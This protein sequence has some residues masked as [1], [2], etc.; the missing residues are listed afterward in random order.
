MAD[1]YQNRPFPSADRGRGADQQRPGSESDPLAELARLIGQADPFASS[2]QAAAAPPEPPEPA[3]AAPDRRN[4]PMDYASSSQDSASGQLNWMRRANVQAQPIQP[5]QDFSNVVSPPPRHQFVEPELDAF[6]AEEQPDFSRYDDVLY[7]QIK[8]GE[9]D[10]HRDPA[11]PDDPYA[12]END[13]FQHSF[14]EDQPENRRR[15]MAK[16]A[17]IIALLA[18]VGTGGAYAF[19]TFVGPRHRG[20]PPIIRADNAPTKIMPASTDN[21]AQVPDRPMGDSAEKMVPR[22]EAPVDVNA[23]TSRGPRVVL[24]PSNQSANATLESGVP[25]PNNGTMPSSEPRRIRTQAVVPGG[26]QTDSATPFGGAPQSTAATPAAARNLPASANASANQPLSE[27]S[28]APPA[29]PVSQTRTAAVAPT[30]APGSGGYMVSISSQDSEAAAKESFRIALSKYPSVIGS[31]ALVV[32][33]VDL[34]DGRVKYRAMV[35]PY[36]TR[37]EA[38][39]FCTELKAAG[40][41]CF[42]P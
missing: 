5:Q 30:A 15:G 19:R 14:D 36:R 4:P 20:D 25:A 23:T 28:Q 1:R 22:E 31:H 33:R 8:A 39:Q 38:V 27:P 40:G 3:R 12:Y 9:Q 29:R 21:T 7:D 26:D 13:Q 2:G 16:I 42:I 17:V 10:F 18:V 34:A 37:P 32:T 11:Y 6:Q 41:Q 35:G 24:L